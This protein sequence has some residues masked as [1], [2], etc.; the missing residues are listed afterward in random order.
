MTDPIS[1]PSVMDEDNISKLVSAFAVVINK[2]RQRAIIHTG[3][4]S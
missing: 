2:I 3:V 1:D 4:Q